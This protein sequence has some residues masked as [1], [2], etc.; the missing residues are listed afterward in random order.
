[1]NSYALTVVLIIRLEFHWL[2]LMILV[3]MIWI[4]LC[5]KILN[6]SKTIQYLNWCLNQYLLYYFNWRVT[7]KDAYFVLNF[8]CCNIQV[9]PTNLILF[10][11]KLTEMLKNAISF[12]FIW[13]KT[14]LKSIFMLT[15]IAGNRII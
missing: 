9:V 5:R 12:R 11:T 3:L 8:T 10:A 7:S 13:L 15:V 4:K 14:P 2:L 1:M 6:V